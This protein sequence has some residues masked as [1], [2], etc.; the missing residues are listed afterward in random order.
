MSVM[1]FAHPDAPYRVYIADSRNGVVTGRYKVIAFE[2]KAETE[3]WLSRHC[4][5]WRLCDS[6]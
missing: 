6:P 5:H 2:T 3:Q 4:R 1:R